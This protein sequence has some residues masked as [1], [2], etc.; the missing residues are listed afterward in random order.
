MKQNIKLFLSDVSEERKYLL[1]KDM[2][3]CYLKYRISPLEYFLFNFESLPPKARE[4]YLSDKVIY[5]TM[6]KKVGRKLHD[7][8]LEDKYNFYLIAKDYFKRK[9]ILVSTYKDFASFVDFCMRFHDI[10]IKPVHSACGHGIYVAHIHSE[11][12]ARLAFEKMVS[13]EDEMIVEELI[14]QSEEMAVWNSSSVNTIRI[15]SFLSGAKFSIL[16]PFMRT[17]RKGVVVDNAGQGGLFAAVDADTGLVITD[18]KDERCNV[19]KEHPDSHVTYKGWKVPQWNELLAMAEKVHHLFPKH[20]YVAWDF[21]H[22]KNGWVLI[23]GNWG[24]F[25]CQQSTMERGYKKEFI[26]FING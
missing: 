3:R 19:Y 18:A 25:V 10:I 21:A 4:E 14:Q 20:K 9:A 22:T 1:G 23:E 12:E 2:S 24:E 16:C 6:A 17:G 7:E 15:S 8:Q 13:D 11:E 5:M 26:N